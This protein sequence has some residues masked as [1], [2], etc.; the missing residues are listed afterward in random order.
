M[1]EFLVVLLFPVVVGIWL[2]VRI[3]PQGEE[4]VAE[5]LGRFHR[6]MDPGLQWH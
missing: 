1:I 3:V 2:G 5:R 6:V 4:W